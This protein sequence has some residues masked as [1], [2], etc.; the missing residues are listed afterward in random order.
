MDEYNL[1]IHPRCFAK[2]GDLCKLAE[3]ANVDVTGGAKIEESNAVAE[4]IA[5]SDQFLKDYGTWTPSPCK[6]GDLT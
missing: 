5:A 4:A 3:K 2:L 6:T 1:N